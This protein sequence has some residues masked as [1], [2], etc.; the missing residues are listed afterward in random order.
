MHFANY[1]DKYL[2]LIYYQK[3]EYSEANR[4]CKEARMIAGMYKDLESVMRADECISKSRD[5]MSS[6]TYQQQQ[7][8]NRTSTS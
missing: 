7:Q 6:D 2:I 3:G 4:V 8:Q 5:E 1:M